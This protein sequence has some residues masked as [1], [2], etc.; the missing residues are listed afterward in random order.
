MSDD[1]DYHMFIDIDEEPEYYKQERIAP[2]RSAVRELKEIAT[3]IITTLKAEGIIIQRYD[4]YS[5]NSIYLKLDYGMCNSIRISDHKGKAGL[6]YRYNVRTDMRKYL[7]ETDSRGF[8]RHYY[9]SD[10]VER[11]IRQIMV[12]RLEVQAKSG[13]TTGY[14]MYMKM[15]KIKNQGEAGFWKES[16]LV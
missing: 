15:N 7:D 14:Q 5:T 11:M 2:S 4:A 3:K 8:P 1:M 16:V 12:R 9:P 10:Q 13:G 6:S